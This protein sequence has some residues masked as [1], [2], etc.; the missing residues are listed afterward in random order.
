M[1]GNELR[2]AQDTLGMSN[3]AFCEFLGVTEATLC[4]WKSGRRRIPHI[5]RFAVET[6]LTGKKDVSGFSGGQS[7]SI[8]GVGFNTSGVAAERET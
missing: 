6:K 7:G 3:T 8:A 5:V 1:T 4:N 2:R